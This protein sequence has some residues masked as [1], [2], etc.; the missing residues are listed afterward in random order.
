MAGTKSSAKDFDDPR[1]TARLPQSELR[2]RAILEAAIR[3]IGDKGLDKL[4]HRSVALEAKVPLGSTTYYFRSRAALIREAF[5]HYLTIADSVLGGLVWEFAE[6]TVDGIVG[7]IVELM[8]R[9]FFYPNLVRA[10]YELLVAASRDPVLSR[11]FR[12]WERA[13][14]GVFT[15]WFEHLGVARPFDAARSVWQLMR[16]FELECLTHPEPP[17]DDLARRLR[18]VIEG[19]ADLPSN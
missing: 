7:Y 15:E 13:R 5:R 17:L 9:E 19:L 18:S 3:V 2:R 12:D 8:R 6:T 14:L 16:G 4:T 10:E 11:E 1:E